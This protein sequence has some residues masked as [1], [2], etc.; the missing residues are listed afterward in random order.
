MHALT[1][2]GGI[3]M[4][5]GVSGGNKQD[6]SQADAARQWVAAIYFITMTI[7]TVSSC[8]PCVRCHA[9]GAHIV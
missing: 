3:Y 4:T 7:T 5:C 8:F 2:N 6:L 9:C 1:I